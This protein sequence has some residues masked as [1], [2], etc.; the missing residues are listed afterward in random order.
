MTVMTMLRVANC[1]M[2]TEWMITQQG[3]LGFHKVV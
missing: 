2:T 1:I 3:E